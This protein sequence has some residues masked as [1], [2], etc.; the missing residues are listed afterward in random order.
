M[1]HKIRDSIELVLS[2]VIMMF[3]VIFFGLVVYALY[4]MLHGLGIIIGVGGTA[5]II[6]F[7]Y[8]ADYR[9]RNIFMVR[10]G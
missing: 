3:I 8:W 7:L 5:S 2:G 9:E 10:G 4:L 6:A 1:E